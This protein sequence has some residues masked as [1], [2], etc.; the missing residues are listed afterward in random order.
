MYKTLIVEK[1][2]NLCKIK[3]NRPKVLNALS[4]ELLQE[5]Q[6]AL[7]D[8]SKDASIRAVLI[9]GEGRGF[10]SGADLGNTS[11]DTDI[12]KIIE[13]NYNPVARLIYNMP[14]PVIAAVNGVAAGAGMSLAV[15]CDM[16]I[17]ST[18]S[19]F[20]LG[21]TG[22]ALV[23][24]ASGSYFLPKLI[25][26]AKSL[27]LAYTNRKVFA[28]EAINI[29]LGEVLFE[30][31]EFDRDASLYAKQIAL[32]PTNTFGLVKRQINESYNNN[33]EEQLALEAKLQAVAASSA[34]AAE[35]IASFLQKRKPKFQGR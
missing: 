14:K 24:D 29:G 11:I 33:F 8:A 16:R 32:G 3:L 15:A 34:D 12:G 21:F 19:A 13:E 4:L 30:A 25:G 2:D 27:E 1:T 7:K 6:I 22:I 31:A 23:M 26:R 28:E 35:G 5:L 9:T 20:A 17:L 18:E 10:C